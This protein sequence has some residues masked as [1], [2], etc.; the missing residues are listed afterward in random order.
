M[1]KKKQ[2][3]RRRTPTQQSARDTVEAAAHVS[4]RH[5]YAAGTTNRIATRAGVSV[6]SVYQYFPNKNALLAAVHLSHRGAGRRR[7]HGVR[8]ELGSE[9]IGHE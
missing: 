2:I 9:Q 4:A 8:G 1:R 7:G 6:G 3:Q 5:G